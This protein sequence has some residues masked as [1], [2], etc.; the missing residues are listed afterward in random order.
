MGDEVSN[1]N[2]SHLNDSDSSDDED[3][4]P[5][6]DDLEDIEDNYEDDQKSDNDENH[7]KPSVKRKRSPPKVW[8]LIV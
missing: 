5:T 2:P 6:N 1:H 3:Y 7:N 4:V 8:T